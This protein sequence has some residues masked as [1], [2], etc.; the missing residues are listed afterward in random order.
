M[1]DWPELSQGRNGHGCGHFVNTDKKVVRQLYCIHVYPWWP[2]YYDQVYLVAGGHSSYRLDSTEMLLHGASSWT[3]AGPL[4]HAISGLQVV[5]LDNQVISTGEFT[6]IDDSKFYV[7]NC[8]QEATVA[9]MV[10][11]MVTTLP[12]F[13]SLTLP[14]CPGTRLGEWLR[15]GHTMGSAWS[16]QQM[17]NSSVSKLNFKY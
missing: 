13:W 14:P 12:P 1:A 10:A 6:S 11:T 5:S 2:H 4:P 9:T 8:K 3:E 16:G 17:W 15:L 7:V